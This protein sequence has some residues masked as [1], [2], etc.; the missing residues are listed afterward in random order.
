MKH[1]KRWLVASSLLLLCAC[2][3]TDDDDDLM[4]D[5][6]FESVYEPVFL[7]RANLESSIVLKEP[8][9]IVNSGKIYL[10]DNLLF[11]NE[12]RF[13]QHRRTIRKKAGAK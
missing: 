8:E 13:D 6:I 11:V 7:S 2:W 3:L 9:P 4:I 10:K 1:L 5:P 12:F